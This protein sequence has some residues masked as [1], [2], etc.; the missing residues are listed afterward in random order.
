MRKKLKKVVVLVLCVMTLLSISTTDAFAAIRGGQGTATIV[1]QTKSNY[2]Y[3]GSSSITL[4]QSKQ[5]L[6]YQ[7]L[8][9][10]KKKTQKGYY[11]YYNITISNKTKRT[12]QKI[13]WSGGKSKKIKLQGNCVYWITVSYN[14]SATG[15][16]KRTPLGYYLKSVSVPSWWLSSIYKVSGYR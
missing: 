1:V 8:W 2:W 6:T 12:T 4:K 3:P 11:G 13:T 5:T 15:S 10:N 7:K 9:G 16:F 14:A